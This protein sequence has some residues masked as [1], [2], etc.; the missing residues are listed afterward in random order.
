MYGALE[1]KDADIVYA[2]HLGNKLAVTMKL[3]GNKSKAQSLVTEFI[4]FDING[5]I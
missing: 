4:M 1:Y 2:R 3:Y 5:N